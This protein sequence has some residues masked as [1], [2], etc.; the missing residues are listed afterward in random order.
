MLFFSLTYG[1]RLNVGLL[2]SLRPG[3][4]RGLDCSMFGTIR[5]SD[6]LPV[7]FPGD[8]QE[9][10]HRSWISED[11]SGNEG[12]DA[13]EGNSDFSAQGDSSLDSG[14]DLEM[15]DHLSGEDTIFFE[16]YDHHDPDERADFLE[17][18]QRGDNNSDHDPQ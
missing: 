5:R 14:S 18:M 16:G 4:R 9:Q 10:V 1:I 12:Y 13:S 6:W 11:G 3:S 17:P 8:P 2:G 15:E 7:G